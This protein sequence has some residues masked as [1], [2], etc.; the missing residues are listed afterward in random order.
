MP[1]L[2]EEGLVLRTD[3]GSGRAYYELATDHPHH[4]VVCSECGGVAHFH[5][6]ALT[7]ARVE[8][9]RASGFRLA[10]SELTF[11]GLCPGCAGREEASELE[12]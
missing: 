9:E 12:T 1:W 5:E 4:H 6:D 11:V 2:L 8:I 7:R 10:A 3:L